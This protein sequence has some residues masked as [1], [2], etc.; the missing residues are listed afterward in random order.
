[1][2]GRIGCELS[3]VYKGIAMF[4]GPLLFGNGFEKCEPSEPVSAVLF[5]GTEDTYCRDDIESSVVTWVK[6]NGCNS[7]GTARAVDTYMSATT[8]CRR[9]TGCS[10]D[11]FVEWCLI[12]DLAH[13][14]AGHTEPG[15]VPTQNSTNV[16]GMVYIM[17]R[18]SS[19][20][21]YA[22]FAS[23]VIRR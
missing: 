2:A 1:M 14:F 4:E 10:G 6:A 3:G 9:F 7:T 13:K 11:T 5:C 18:F 16:D 17:D 23:G 22:P 8:K 19:I 12:Q 15:T 20:A 21:R